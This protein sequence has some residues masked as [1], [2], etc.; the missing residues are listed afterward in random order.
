MI[1]D[2]IKNAKV[3]AK[4]HAMFANCINCDLKFKF[5]ESQ[6]QGKYCT[7]KCQKEYEVNNKHRLWLE[8]EDVYKSSKTLKSAVIRRDGYSCNECNISDWNK[9]PLMLELEHVD[10]NSSNNKSENVCL[11]CPNCHSQTSTF[12]GKNKGNGR[13]NRKMRYRAGKSF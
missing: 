7:N 2:I 11:N 1:Y 6:R 13:H 12:K 3:K 9:K 10:G 5:R 8:G 4:R